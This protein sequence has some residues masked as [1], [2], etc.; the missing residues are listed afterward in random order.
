MS[1]STS[2]RGSVETIGDRRIGQFQV[3]LEG[4]KIRQALEYL[5]ESEFEVEVH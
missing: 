1:M 2:E 5:H 3:E 4:D